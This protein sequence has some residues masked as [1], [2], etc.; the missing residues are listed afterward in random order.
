MGTRALW[1]G[2]VR[3]EITVPLV[4]SFAKLR[5]LAAVACAKLSL[6]ALVLH[7]FLALQRRVQRGTLRAIE[8]WKGRAYRRRPRSSWPAWGSTTAE[9]HFLIA[10]LVD[11]QGRRM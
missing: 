2:A 4:E 10:A 11:L 7:S 9:A 5:T 6:T 3:R 8:Q 1:A